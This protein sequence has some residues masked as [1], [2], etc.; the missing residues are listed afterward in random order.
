MIV[1]HADQYS[2]ATLLNLSCITSSLLAIIYVFF[3]LYAEWVR[4]TIPTAAE[5]AF[6]SVIFSYATIMCAIMALA[7][8][9][10]V[11]QEKVAVTKYRITTIILTATSGAI[12][13]LIKFILPL[14]YFWRPLGSAW[15]HTLSKILMVVTAML[16]G[17]S[18]L[19]NTIYAYAVEFIRGLR[20]WPAYKDLAD[21]ADRLERLCPP[22]LVDVKRPSLTNFSRNYEY[23]LYRST[24]R[25]LDC[26]TM[27]VD[28]LNVNAA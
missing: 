12:Y 19:H 23:H 10:Y 11:R 22:I 20:Y 7:C 25:I 16:W 3:V 21:L 27:L 14:G 24:I 2:P 4:G 28:F 5:V 1:P 9:R 18:F 8:Y 26:K 13:F 15:I 17:G 6:K